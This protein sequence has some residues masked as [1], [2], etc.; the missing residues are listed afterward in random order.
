MDLVHSLLGSATSLRIRRPFHV[1]RGSKIPDSSI[2]NLHREVQR[3]SAHE[4]RL[5]SA[6]RPVCA[7]AHPGMCYAS[8]RKTRSLRWQPSS[9]RWAQ[10]FMSRRTRHSSARNESAQALQD[11]RIECSFALLARDRLALFQAAGVW[12]VGCL[13]LA[14]Y[15][16]ESGDKLTKEKQCQLSFFQ[17]TQGGPWASVKGRCPGCPSYV[18][19]QEGHFLYIMTAAG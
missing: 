7:S 5:Y 3:L 8:M 1:F 18:G 12:S 2:S 13:L 15:S 14:S 11:S 17:S 4:V 6:C 10:L 19:L 16:W 9:Q